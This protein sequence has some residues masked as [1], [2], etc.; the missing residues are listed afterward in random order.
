MAD[1][2]ARWFKG[3]AQTIINTT[4]SMAA[5]NFTTASGT[6]FATT[7]TTDVQWAPYGLATLYVNEF[8]A[9]P[10]SGA[11]IS[12]YGVLN[13]VDGTSDDTNLPS[14]T[15]GQATP[16]FFGSFPMA[17]STAAQRRTIVIDLLGVQDCDFYCYN[18]TAQ[19]WSSSAA[20]STLKITPFSIGVST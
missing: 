2:P 9:A 14:G 5:S 6:L 13:N 3:T 19:T 11:V 20:N 12:L 4:G 18:G 7:A 10:T 1:Y 8:L 16:R 17:A 15:T